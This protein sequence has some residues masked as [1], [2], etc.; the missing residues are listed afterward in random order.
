MARFDCRD[1]GPLKIGPGKG[2]MALAGIWQNV[3]NMSITLLTRFAFKAVRRKESA[4]DL[5]GLPL[6][7]GGETKP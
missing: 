1:E 5:W 7:E 6:T 3:S 2:L 4:G